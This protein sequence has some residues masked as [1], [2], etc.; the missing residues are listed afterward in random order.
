MVRLMNP[1]LTDNT[2][3][4][5]LLT[6]PLFIGKDRSADGQLTYQSITSLDAVYEIAAGNRLSSLGRAKDQILRE[7]QSN[8]RP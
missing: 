4:I 7:C 2:K 1:D 5:L 6:A 3:A 8:P